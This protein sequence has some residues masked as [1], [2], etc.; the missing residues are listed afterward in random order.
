[1]KALEKLPVPERVWMQLWDYFEAAARLY[2]V[3]PL[4]KL[5]EIY[6]R[7]NSPVSEALFLEFAE[8]LRHDYR[9]Y[10]ILNCDALKQHEPMASPLD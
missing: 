9:P 5:L 3:I 8:I 1:M 2:G 6:N 7:Y 4:R 10:S